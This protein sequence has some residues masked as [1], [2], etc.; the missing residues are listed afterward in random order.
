MAAKKQ[1]SVLSEL[2]W[3]F[4]D[5]P[6][7]ELV[8]CCYWEF[9]RESA[10]I[11]L[12]ADVNWSR[13]RSI[14]KKEEYERNPKVKAE[15]EQEA[16]RIEGRAKAAGF[17]YAAFAE[18]FW[19][20]DLSAVAIYESLTNWARSGVRP[21][22]KLPKK[23]RAHLVAAVSKRDFLQALSP[24]SVGELEQLWNANRSELDKVRSRPR[25]DYDDS[26]DV[27]LL[28]ES[29][30]IAL[31]GE[32]KD[33]PAGKLAVAFT[34]DFARFTDGEILAQ[35]KLWLKAK[36]PQPWTRPLRVLPDSRQKGR[37]LIEYRV[38]LERLGLMRL[39]HWHSPA[40]LRRELPEAWAKYAKKKADFR[41]EV[42]QA[43]KFFRRLFPFLPTQERPASESR[44]GVWLPE[45]HKLA[46]KVERE[47]G[48]A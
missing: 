36:R 35:F 38:A 10:T 15:D 23:T 44:V 11:G 42:R 24:A 5:V 40:E 34:V 30:C 13:V 18:R 14:W 20:T 22:S 47:M 12:A 19:A 48:M 25:T 26:E 37:K 43:C 46:D 33:P 7:N 32:A 9:A 28:W 31:S 17:H 21:W 2:D 3:N 4:D 1:F 39:L 16:S 8:A 29:E 6:D 27:A 45:M 41:R